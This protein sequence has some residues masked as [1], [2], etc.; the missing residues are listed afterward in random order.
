MGKSLYR[1]LTGRIEAR[2][3]IRAHTPVTLRQ[4]AMEDLSGL[5]GRS[6]DIITTRKGRGDER[7]R[8]GD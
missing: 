2:K 8:K 4:A 6:G 7:V 3:G 1:L 5:M